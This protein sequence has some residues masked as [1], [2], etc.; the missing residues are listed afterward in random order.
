MTGLR[1][2][3]M[4]DLQHTGF[5]SVTTDLGRAMLERGMDV[6]FLSQND[7]GEL[8]EPFASRALD[9][10]FYQYQRTLDDPGIAGVRGDLVGDIVAGRS[11]AMLADGEPW[12]TWSPEA[13]V[14]LGDFVGVRMLAMR[15]GPVLGTVPVFHYCPV[16]GVDLPPAWASLWSALRPVAMS[17]FGQAEIAKV[18]GTEPPLAYH[19]V[20]TTIFRPVSASDP[21]VVPSRE[22]PEARAVT[23]RSREACRAF[24]GFDPGRRYVLRTDRNMP[25]KRY[26]SLLRAMAP[27]LAERPDVTLVIHCGAF[28]QGGFLPDSISKMPEAVRS[29]VLVT[30]RPG[31]PREVLAALYNAADVYASTSAEGF[32]LTIAEALACGVPAVGMD[33]SAVP[34]V[35]GPGGAVVPVAQ[36]YDNEYDHKWAWPDEGALGERVAY[37]LDHPAK[38]RALGDAGRRH[39]A[40]TFRW[41]DAAE[42]FDGLLSAAAEARGDQS[43]PEAGDFAFQLAGEAA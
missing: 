16:E 34:E 8:P 1:V 31:L 29:Q 23:L 15:I 39:V 33:Y 36:L 43:I 2:L 40:A 24:F 13:V 3:F 38:A 9:V 19:G 4:G 35:I 32:G 11:D 17:R 14:M 22:G 12:G 37:L 25:R 21:M 42:A 20:D 10:A 26:G 28:D 27:V 5:G 30:D 6:R 7:V 41:A 18:T